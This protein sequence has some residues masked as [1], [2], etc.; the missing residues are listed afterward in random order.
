MALHNAKSERIIAIDV[1]CRGPYTGG[2]SR[3]SLSI[4][5]G[6][7]RHGATV[8]GSIDGPEDVVSL[9]FADV[10]RAFMELKTGYSL[11]VSNDILMFAI[12]FVLAIVVTYWATDF[13]DGP[14][15]AQDIFSATILGGTLFSIPIAVALAKILRKLFPSFECEI[16]QGSQRISDHKTRRSQV[17]YGV[18]GAILIAAFFWYLSR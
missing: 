1:D 18:V 4:E 12:G 13:I 10:E 5:E 11:L 3:L 15:T 17:G 7:Y 2:G 9:V 16:G 14:H 6:S 8:R